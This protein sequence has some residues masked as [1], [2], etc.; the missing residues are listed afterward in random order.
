MAPPIEYT[1]NGRKWLFPILTPMEL[2]G[3]SKAFLKRVDRAGF[4]EGLQLIGLDRDEQEDRLQRMELEAGSAAFIGRSLFKIENAMDA[5]RVSVARLPVAED[6]APIDEIPI[7]D[8]SMLAIDV[9]NFKAEAPDKDA[10]PDDVNP[11][12]AGDQSTGIGA[13]R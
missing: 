2:I 10:D 5:L 12:K 8:L 6:R 4:V 7:G 13:P 3:L 9:C 11:T 1:M